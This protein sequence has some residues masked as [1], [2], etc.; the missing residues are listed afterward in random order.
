V[1][2]QQGWWA[3]VAEAMTGARREKGKKGRELRLETC[4][5]LEGAREEKTSREQPGAK[6]HK[7]PIQELDYLPLLYCCC[8]PLLLH[9]EA[10][11]FLLLPFNVV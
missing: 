6:S 2:A 7:A 4:R 11:C 10:C 3:E 9:I 5:R 1:A 8:A